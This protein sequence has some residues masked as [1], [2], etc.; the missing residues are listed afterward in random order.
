VNLSWDAQSGAV[1]YNVKRSTTPD[2]PYQMIAPS[3]VLTASAFTDATVTAGTTYYYVASASSVAGEGPDSAESA[4]STESGT[5]MPDF[6]LSASPDYATIPTPGAS[7]APMTL[8]VNG[9]NGYNGT[10]SY[11]IIVSDNASGKSKYVQLQ[12]AFDYRER[13]YATDDQYNA[14]GQLGSGEFFWR[15]AKRKRTSREWHLHG[16]ADHCGGFQEATP[17]QASFRFPCADGAA[18]VVGVWR[19]GWQ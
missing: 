18:W 13:K 14:A 7:S 11:A 16:F 1:R 10:T 19:V 4:V 17:S 5:P 15:G 9:T 3:P 12:S 6:T 2:G 8:T